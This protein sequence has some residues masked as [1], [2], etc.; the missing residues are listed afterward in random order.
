MLALA[1]K[2]SDFSDMAARKQHDEGRPPSTSGKTIVSQRPIQ[3]PDR[4]MADVR[5]RS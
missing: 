2:Y 3:R 5:N 4:K 1:E